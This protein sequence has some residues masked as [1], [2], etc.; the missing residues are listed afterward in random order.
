VHSQTTPVQ[1]PTPSLEKID[2]HEICSDNPLNQPLVVIDDGFCVHYKEAEEDA[3]AK[4]TLDKFNEGLNPKPGDC[5]KDVKLSDKWKI[6]LYASNSFTQYFNSNM[7]FNC[8]RYQV[9]IKDYQW[10]ERSSRHFFL[11]KTWAEK[12]H[13]PL[14]II[15]E[16][17]N[18]FMVSIEKD[19]HEFFLSAFH[20]K[21][22]QKKSQV[23][24]VEGTVDGVPVNGEML[25]DTP[26]HGYEHTPG[27]MK[28]ARNQNTY[29]EM[30]YEVGYGYRFK[31][32]DTK[33]GN[34]TYV[35]N[36]AVGVM[37]GNNYSSAVQKGAWWDFED[38][39]D[40]NKI[41]GYGGSIGNRIELNSPKERFGLFYENRL[42]YYKM[43]HGFLDGTQSYDLRY[44]SNQIGMKFMI[45]NPNNRKK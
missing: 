30:N 20:P 15:D 12:G 36:A 16:P 18:R 1:A 10:S 45:Y 13:N 43:N 24:H 22:Y 21:F 38:H 29:R 11:P 40:E 31:L 25:I 3:K 37:V 19:G 5:S 32:L 8:S 7:N 28:V 27:E 44:M 26:F 9:E 39:T 23:S 34:I 35:P 17:T 4:D 6:R 2:L 42:G 14:Q 41:Q 33:L